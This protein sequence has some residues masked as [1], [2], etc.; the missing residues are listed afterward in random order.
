MK[1]THAL[2]RAL[3]AVALAAIVPLAACGDDDDKSSSSKTTDVAFELKGSGKK[4]TMEVPD[5]VK[6]GTT[7][8]TFTNST[9]QEAS[10]QLFRV[11]G[12]HTPKEVRAAGEAWGDKGKPL[13]DWVGL[14]GGTGSTKPGKSVAVT[15]VL[16]PGKYIVADL[17]TS[18]FGEF[19]VTGSGGGKLPTTDASIDAKEYSFDTSGLKAGKSQ[20]VFENKGKEPHFVVGLPIKSGKTI[21]DVKTFVKT[22]KGEAPV[23]EK[24]AFDAAV[25]DGGGKQVVSLQ[26]QKGNYAL[27]CFI[28]DR[29]GGPPHVAKGMVSEATVK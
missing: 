16:P 15:Q 27:L 25:I 11:E 12:D 13:P 4:A 6:A 20:V 19:E 10:G 3:A 21:E 26:L 24:K 28:P 23:D 1:S 14:A 17:E 29:E 18:A 9:K 8:I 22:E 7:R 2:P 5:S